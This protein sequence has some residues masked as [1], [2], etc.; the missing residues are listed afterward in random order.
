M[1]TKIFNV[2]LLTILT[3]AHFSCDLDDDNTT[4]IRGEGGGE[5]SLRFTV[6]TEEDQMGEFA[7]VAMA[8]F[9]GKIYAAGGY[10]AYGSSGSHFLWSSSNG[11][12]WATVPLSSSTPASFTSFRSGATL[13][14]FND[15]LWL[16][17]GKDITDAPYTNIWH[18]ADG[19]SWS[20]L[21][22]PFGDLPAHETIVYN[23]K[24]YVTK[25]NRTTNQTEVW[26]TTNGIDWIQETNNAFPGRGGQKGVVFNDAMYLLGG[27]DIASNKV[28][29]I[30]TSTDGSSWAEVSPTT[31]FS[32]RNAHSA[33]VYNNKV[34]VIGGKD[35][36]TLFNNEIWYSSD[37][38]TWTRYEGPRPGTDGINS[39]TAL[40]FNDE[41]WIFGSNRSDG[42]GGTHRNG[43]ISSIKED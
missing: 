22:P 34:W 27:E 17:G 18:S 6:Q 41:I 38:I 19:V 5:L 32:E 43:E 14:T 13:T 24:M 28:N 20:E 4:P 8:I 7:G 26:S 36:I 40:L 9:D 16:I 21:S 31:L 23:S 42:T 11:V 30:W 15:Q 12:N 25:G 35:N 33:T 10:N 2:I 3:V 37:M 29:E 39:H 1:K